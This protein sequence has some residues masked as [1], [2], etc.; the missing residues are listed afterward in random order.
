MDPSK[1]TKGCQGCVAKTTRAEVNNYLEMKLDQFFHKAGKERFLKKG[2]VVELPSEMQQSTKLWREP[3]RCPCP[4]SCAVQLALSLS[5]S[6][7][8][9]PVGHG[10]PKGDFFQHFLHKFGWQTG[11]LLLQESCVLP[12]AVKTQ[13]EQGVRLSLKYQQ[14]TAVTRV[15]KKQIIFAAPKH[16]HLSLLPKA[17]CVPQPGPAL[18]QVGELLPSICCNAVDPTITQRNIIRA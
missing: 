3:G 12:N 13:P 5:L 1:R 9:L 7:P 17:G 15:H 6:L 18:G 11:N 8:L 16:H 14:V 2:S 4:A 10:S